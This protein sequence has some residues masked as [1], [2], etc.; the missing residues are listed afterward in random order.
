MPLISA[1]RADVVELWLMSHAWWDG[2]GGHYR[3]VRDAGNLSLKGSELILDALD[4]GFNSGFMDLSVDAHGVQDILNV[5]Q[6]LFEISL[7]AP[8]LHCVGGRDRS[9]LLLQVF[10]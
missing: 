9:G 10:T 6:F 4:G 1:W 2:R 5:R 8:K 7:E 3:A